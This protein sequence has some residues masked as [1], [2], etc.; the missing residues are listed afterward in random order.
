[1]EELNY[2]RPKAKFTSE[3]SISY[4]NVMYVHANYI[5]VGFAEGR[6]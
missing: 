5:Y 4:Y 1:M 6:G 3:W 2:A